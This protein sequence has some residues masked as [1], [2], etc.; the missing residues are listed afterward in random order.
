MYSVIGS[1]HFKFPQ[2]TGFY[3]GKVRDVYFIGN[4]YLLSIATDRI[5]AFDVILP[6]HIPYKGQVLNQLAAFFLKATAHI[7]PNWLIDTPD[8]NVS[9]GYRCQPFPIE[10]VVRGYLAGHAWREYASGKRILCGVPLPEGLK[11]NDKL[12]HPIITPTTKASA[13]HDEDISKEAIIKSKLVS[14][15]HY[16][17]IEEMALKLYSKGVEM[18]ANRGLIL[19]DTKYEFG[20][21]NDDILLMDEVHT[22]DSSRYFNAEGYEKRQAE[23]IPQQQ[24]SK[25]FVRQWLMANGFQGKDNQQIPTMTDE[26]VLDISQRYIQLYELLTGTT[27]KAETTDW[28]NRILENVALTLQS[29]TKPTLI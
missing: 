28:E 2:Q 29:A 13:G 17:K 11:E 20:L 6:R 10:V 23:G 19:V 16:E 9:F 3:R 18:A 22:P 14:E 27:F 5:S 26:V 15:A 21:H 25:E 24:L 7:V 8:P 1:S 4:E 12:P